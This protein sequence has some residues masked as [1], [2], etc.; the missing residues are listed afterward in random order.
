MNI[1]K[2]RFVRLKQQ[3]KY[4][5]TKSTNYMFVKH[6]LITNTVSSGI[7]MAMGDAI[8]Q[9]IE[10]KNQ[11]KTK[12]FDYDRMGRMFWVGILLGPLHHVYYEYVDRIW[13]G[14]TMRDVRKKIYA[15][16]FIASP[17]TI[18]FFFYGMGYLEKKNLQHSTDELVD[19]FGWVYLVDWVFWPPVQF[20]NFYFLPSKYRLL[21]INVATMLFDI[22]LSKIKHSKDG[23]SLKD[24]V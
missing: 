12:R 6:L 1:L 10:Y 9:D 8:Q 16:Q 7:L 11:L 22:F 24:C 3:I 20:V 14:S 19:K 15:D 5:Y 23:L 2:Y 4:G 13:P 17:L 18:V 21:Y